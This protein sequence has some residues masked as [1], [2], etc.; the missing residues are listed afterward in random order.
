MSIRQKLKDKIANYKAAKAD[1][2]NRERAAKLEKVQKKFEEAIKTFSNIFN[3]FVHD[4]DDAAKHYQEF[5]N[6]VTALKTSNY[7]ADIRAL[8]FDI[9]ELQKTS[10]LLAAPAAKLA[11]YEMQLGISLGS[12]KSVDDLNLPDYG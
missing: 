12:D 3:K 11:K 8:V 2:K 1:K 9:A 10:S 6:S 4:W 5:H 7:E